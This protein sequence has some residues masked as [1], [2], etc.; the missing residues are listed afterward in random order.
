MGRS[1]RLPPALAQCLRPPQEPVHWG[2]V[3]HFRLP[4]LTMALMWGRRH[5]ATVSRSRAGSPHRPRSTNGFSVARGEPAAAL[6]QQARDR[7]RGRPPGPGATL[8]VSRDASQP[9]NRGTAMAAVATLQAP[10]TA[11]AIPGHQAVWALLG[12]HNHVMPWGLRR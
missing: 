5:L 1:I 11:A 7:L 12:Y 4:G 3:T 6:C 9:T 10:P 8:Y 2:H